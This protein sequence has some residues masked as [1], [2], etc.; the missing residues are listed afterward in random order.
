VLQRQRPL[1]RKLHFLFITQNENHLKTSHFSNS[2]MTSP[3]TVLSPGQMYA[4][5]LKENL[6]LKTG[7]KSFR[8]FYYAGG[9][10]ESRFDYFMKRF[11]KISLQPDFVEECECTHWIKENCYVEYMPADVR[12]RPPKLFVVGNCCIRKF[13]PLDNQGK[14]CSDCR[15]PHKNRKDNFCIPCREKRD[16]RRCNECGE[17]QKKSNVGYCVDCR[18][19]FGRR[20]REKQVNETLQILRRPID[21]SAYMRKLDRESNPDEIDVRPK[22]VPETSNCVWPMGKYKG[23]P[24]YEIDRGYASWA[25]TNI[26]PK[27]STVRMSLG[28]LQNK[29]AL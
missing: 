11:G 18:A 3:S 15:M 26:C 24:I 29:F 22:Y 27:T 19:A 5:L 2:R 17:K 12:C 1:K 7:A 9:N 6:F 16:G 21:I 25:V 4:Q 10:K 8:D 13:L 28:Y 20:M 23:K 14:T